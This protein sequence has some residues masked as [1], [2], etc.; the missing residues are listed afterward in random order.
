MVV[1]RNNI[2]TVEYLR[3]KPFKVPEGTIIT[4]Y[5]KDGSPYPQY[6]VTEAFMSDS[7]QNITVQV[8]GDELECTS[9]L[10]WVL[11]ANGKVYLDLPNVEF[12]PGD[13]VY[14]RNN[15]KFTVADEESCS[16]NL[17]EV[18]C[19]VEG[20]KGVYL[21]P[22]GDLNFESNTEIPGESTQEKDWFIK[23][24][25]LVPVDTV[26]TYTVQ[27]S[28]KD[29]NYVYTV[30]DEFMSNS[31]EDIRVKGC[32]GE[33]HSGCTSPAFYVNYDRSSSISFELPDTQV[34]TKTVL[35]KDQT[36]LDEIEFF[37]STPTPDQF[38]AML[39]LSEL[40]KDLYDDKPLDV[41]NSAGGIKF[42]SKK[43]RP[44]LLLKSM[45]DAVQE[46]IDVLELGARKYAPDNWKKVENERYHDAMLRHVLAYLGGETLDQ[47]T[48]RHHLAHA[49]CNMLFLIQK[50]GATVPDA[51]EKESDE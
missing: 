36:T 35:F 3:G 24:P 50:E 29:H 25:F 6:C 34:K 14:N 43:A 38:K 7:L 11:Y 10:Y 26:V 48:S 33:I 30:L 44:T 9:P 45:P 42:D 12:M 21:L 13:I 22:R 40:S 49:V 20:E 23:E 32:N 8:S 17:T 51:K 27:L 18:Y 31:T 1:L 4:Y 28:G 5:A 2:Y 19:R 37:P 47:E 41:P 16:R 39:E 46:V 15:K